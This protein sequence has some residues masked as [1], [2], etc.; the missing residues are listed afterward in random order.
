L[1]NEGFPK[2]NSVKLRK[3][4]RAIARNN[5]TTV[6]GT[7]LSMDLD[8]EA[9]SGQDE[10][11]VT[12]SR[13]TVAEYIADLNRIFV[14]EEIPGWDPGIR[15][16]AR[17]RTAP[18]RIFVDP[19]LAIAALGVGH[20]HLA[21]D[22][23][24]FGFMFENLCI[25]DLSAY[26]AMHGGHIYH[27]HDNSGL[28][29]DAVMEFQDGSWAAFEI[30]LGEHQAEAAAQSLMRLTKKMA[31]GGASA[32]KCLVVITGGGL[33][34]ARPDGVCVIPIHALRP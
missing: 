10:E 26:A 32:P 25:R 21:D 20:R 27:Y 3:L 29:A 7:T 2:R 13:N 28:E 6:K 30:K 8:G 4:L 5:A 12:I 33:C 15:S 16:K 34:M 31:E 9:R 14:L 11:E 22:L 1:F 18:K 24:T 23:N 17:A 19:S